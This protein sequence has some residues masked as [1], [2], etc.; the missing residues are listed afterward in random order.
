MK[1]AIYYFSGTGNTEL[2]VKKWASEASK[3]NIECDLF[4][5]EEVTDKTID[6]NN[7]DKVGIAYP[8]HAFNAPRIVLKSAK[9]F[10]KCDSQ[11]P[12]F[13]VMVSGE[14]MNLN[15]SSHLKLKSILKKRNM[16]L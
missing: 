13:V 8:I 1:I 6:V 12:F 11:K 4:K 14:Y 15:H 10:I 5:F 16:T 2:T 7:Y 9:K 3:H